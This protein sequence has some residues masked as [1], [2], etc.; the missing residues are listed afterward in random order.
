MLFEFQ[1]QEKCRDQEIESLLG[2]LTSWSECRPPEKVEFLSHEIQPPDHS[3]LSNT[4]VK[5]LQIKLAIL[6][7]WQ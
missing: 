2:I 1:S 7:T 3:P 5:Q 6:I 4:I